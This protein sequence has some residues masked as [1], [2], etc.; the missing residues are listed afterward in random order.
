M[1]DDDSGTYRVT[2]T[3]YNRDPRT[4]CFVYNTFF[5]CFRL[6]ANDG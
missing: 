1:N 5:F 4:E 2:G 6:F 3:Q